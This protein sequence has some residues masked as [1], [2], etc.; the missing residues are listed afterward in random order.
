MVIRKIEMRPPDGDYGDELHPKTSADIVGVTDTAGKLV[1]TDVENALLELV[2]RKVESSEKASANGVATLDS[3]GTVPLAQ[4]KNGSTTQRGILQLSDST[5]ST[6][7]N[8]AATAAAVKRAYDLAASK[9]STSS[10][11]TTNDGLMSSSDKTKLDSVQSG[12]E[13]NQNAFSKV[14]VGGVIIDADS[15]TDTLN[16]S[17]G[18]AVIMTPNATTDSL[19]IAVSLSDSHTDTSKVKAATADAVRRLKEES[20]LKAGSNFMSGILMEEGV[21]DLPNSTKPSV[22]LAGIAYNTH[23]RGFVSN[24]TGYPTAYG[25]IMGFATSMNGYTYCWQL[26]KASTANSKMFYRSAGSID[27][28]GAWVELETDASVNQKLTDLE[29]ELRAYTDAH[30]SPESTEPIP[31]SRLAEPVETPTGAQAKVD[32]HGNRV[33]NPHAVTTSQVNV[34]NPKPAAD[35]PSTYPIGITLFHVNTVGEGYPSGLGTVVTNTINIHRTAQV[36]YAKQGSSYFRTAYGEVWTAWEEYETTAGSQARVN[37]HASSTT[38]ITSAERTTW[39]AKE[40]TTGAQSK[41]DAAETSALNAAIAWVRDYGLGAN[42]KLI[43]NG[44]LNA[45]RGTGFFRGSGLTGAPDTGW[46]YIFNQE[47]ASTYITQTAF[48]LNEAPALFMR[49]NNGGVW[50]GWTEFESTYGAQARVDS[51]SGDS[52]RHITS[53]ERTSWNSKET[54]T[55]AQTK[56]NTAES[57][58]KAYAMNSISVGSTADPNTTQE[59]YILTNHTNAPPGTQYWHIMTLFYSSKTGNRSQIAVA[60]N[61]NP[62]I[63]VRKMY[64]TTWDAWVQMESVAGAAAQISSHM[65]VSATT[66]ARGHVQLSTSTTSTSTTMAATPSAVKA[67]MDQANAAFQSASDG[68]TKIASAITGKGV[69]AEGTETFDQLSAKINQI[70][71]GV[72]QVNWSVMSGSGSVVDNTGRTVFGA[73]PLT[74]NLDDFGFSNG[75]PD[76]LI[77]YRNGAPEV[78]VWSSDPLNTGTGDNTA[79]GGMMYDFLPQSAG[80]ITLPVGDAGFYYTIECYEQATTGIG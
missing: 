41:A 75:R 63:F 54:T 29:A 1:A 73:N 27:S 39:N 78:T 23:Y 6:A 80:E 38:H 69:A 34:I 20:V 60:Y 24:K 43:S 22:D 62:T 30:V 16:L 52:V 33:D 53:A 49:V 50:S 21:K 59:S 66:G 5:A 37:A 58:A 8:L 55:G 77:I 12:A 42:S 40:T 35:S 71:T 64:G 13:V 57:N 74:F 45:L 10:S 51:H 67:A 14:S 28:W 32:A 65:G 76:K 7:V 19:D 9:A 79:Y 3:T 18:T 31:L 48:T 26:F 46:W 68:K 36:F 2:D 17:A 44:D 70:S 61:G 15:K 25:S 56:A 11:T 72:Q 4:L 47:H